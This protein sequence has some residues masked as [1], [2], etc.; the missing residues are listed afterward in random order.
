MEALKEYLLSY[1]LPLILCLLGAVLLIGGMYSSH[2]F[3]SKPKADFTQA[4]ASIVSEKELSSNFKVDISGAIL[5]PGVYELYLGARVED[6][7]RSAGGF[8]ADANKEFIAKSVNLSQKLSD[9]QKIYIPFEGEKVT[10]SVVLGVAASGS[11]TN[12][13]KI[14]INSASSKDLESLPSVGAVTAA[15]IIDGRPYQKLEDLVDKKVISRTVFNKV[16]GLIDLN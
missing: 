12:S 9:G 4:K 15:K 16:E 8:S 5:N 13:S 6:A 7:V 14:G 11:S 2:I 10:Q 1:K 3:D